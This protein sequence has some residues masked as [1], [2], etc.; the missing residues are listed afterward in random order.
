MCLKWRD[1]SL[2]FTPYC[3][4]KLCANSNSSFLSLSE[5]FRSVKNFIF[6]FLKRSEAWKTSFWSF[7][8]VQ[9]HEKLLFGLSAVCRSMKNFFFVFLQCAEAWKT[10]FLSFC[11]VQKHEK[12]LFCLSAVC[13]SMKNL[14]LAF[15]QCAEA[16]KIS[17]WSF[18]N[19]QKHVFFLFL[20]FRATLKHLKSLF[21]LSAPRL[22]T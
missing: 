21:R 1:I 9:K 19:V 7:C 4:R 22:S 17:I 11:S 3:D 18:W 16:W 15:L 14:S 20:S 5:T 10:S 6:V 13:R 8:S 2:L 12:S